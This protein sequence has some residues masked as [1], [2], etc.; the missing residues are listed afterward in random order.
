MALFTVS[1]ICRIST[2][3]FFNLMELTEKNCYVSIRMNP[4]DDKHMEISIQCKSQE[5]MDYCKSVLSC[6]K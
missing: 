6:S 5:M 4:Y 1:E 2:N 3:T